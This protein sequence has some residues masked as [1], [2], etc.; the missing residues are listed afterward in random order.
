MALSAERKRAL[1]MYEFFEIKNG[2]VVVNLGA[3][4]GQATL[5][6]SR[7]IG[8]NGLVISLEPV[9]ENYRDLIH[10]IVTNKLHNVIPLMIAIS[11]K[12]SESQIYLSRSS[13][14]HSLVCR[15]GRDLGE[16]V[17][18]TIT[19]DDL[20]SRLNITHVDLVKVDIEGAEIAF[21]E[22]MNKVFPD[23]MILEEHSCEP[24][25]SMER[26]L[27]LLKKK[28]YQILDRKWIFIFAQRRK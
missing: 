10:T 18:T 22:G 12:T 8:D 1:A 13:L 26:I 21:L 25:V 4:V 15:H 20:M 24:E 16:R 14:S 17:T 3:H 19:W 6:F 9:F 23:K 11:D 7:K 2:D 28:G 27:A 5:I